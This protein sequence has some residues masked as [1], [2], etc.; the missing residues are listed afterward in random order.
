MSLVAKH[1]ETL[2]P[3]VPGKPVE[4]LERE[5][6]ISEALKLASNE[7]PLGPSPYAVE[8]IKK[9]ASQTHIYPDGAGYKLREKLAEEL[10]VDIDE[11]ILGNGSNELITLAI[12]TFCQ[13]GENAV[14]SDYS[15][16]AY[17][18]CLQAAGVPWTSIPMQDGYVHDLAAMADACDE[19]TKFVFVAN[20]NNPTGTYVGRAELEHFLKTVPEQAIVILDEAYVEYALADDYVSGLE[21]R[22]LRERLIVTRTFSKCYGLA[23]LRVGY[24]VGPAELMS[25]V[26]RVR[27][28]FN[29][30]LVGQVAARAALDD[31]DFVKNAVVSNE[32]G[33]EVLVSG[34]RRL[35][36]EYGTEF[37][38][39]QTNFL[40]I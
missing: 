21:L 40:L 1:I 3:Y 23:G 7:N 14:L 29:A 30:N 25:Y 39:S 26:Q 31:T 8:A 10:D 15:F 27:E 4:E 16:I 32:A 17:R 28:P 34:L 36:R 12:R 33:R 24:G 6:G 18:L 38:H 9:I 22:E 35:Q 37:I 13:P 2:K 11:I 20:P 19:S 5:L